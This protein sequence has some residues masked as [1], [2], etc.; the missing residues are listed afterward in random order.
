MIGPRQVFP[1]DAYL[2][3]PPRT[4]WRRARGC[5]TDRLLER[6]LTQAT[7]ASSRSMIRARVN[8]GFWT[9]DRVLTCE[10]ESVPV[11]RWTHL[12][13]DWSDAAPR[14]FEW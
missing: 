9:V 3:S 7:Y 8:G 11:L 4:P 2:C 1:R 13:M 12:V 6:R 5:N 10:G 14:R